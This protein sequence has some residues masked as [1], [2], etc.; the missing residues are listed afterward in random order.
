[1]INYVKLG[2]VCNV[3]RGTTITKKDTQKGE[4]PVIA[5]GRKATYYHNKSN[6]AAD[7]IT[8]S[9]SGAS[10]GLANYWAIPIF[11]SDCSTVEIK[12]KKQN[13]KFVYYYLQSMQEFIYKN[14]RSGAAQPHVYSKDIANLKFPLFPVKEQQLIVTKL[15]LTFAEIDKVI[16]QTQKL[17]ENT[18]LLFEEKIKQYFINNITNSP[19]VKLS[20]ISEYFNGLTYSPKDVSEDGVIVLRSGNIQNGKMQYQDIKRVKKKIKDKLYVKPTDILMCSRNGS[21]RLIGKS[22]LIG[23]IKEP[24]TF[25]TF[26]MIIRSKHNKY[27]QWFIKSKLFKKQILKGENTMINQITRYMLDDISLPFPD[28]KIHLKIAN[29]LEELDRHIRI[30]IK[31]LDIKIDNFRILKSSI[32]KQKILDKV[33]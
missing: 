22:S 7:V 31:N 17:I 29:E 10:A 20:D 23:E 15:D 14:L 11:A 30:L 2:D 1:M 13:I 33:A 27:L 9:G 26:M 3:R 24:M 6:R 12:D 19:I 5:G 4:V 25:G 32:L 8:I 18:H 21:Q 16:S 28:K